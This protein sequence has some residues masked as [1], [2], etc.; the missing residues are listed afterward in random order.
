MHEGHR[1]RMLQRLKNAQDLQDHELLEI[2]L[3]NAIPRKNT[4]PTAHE[5]LSA[6]PSLSEVFRAG[7]EELLDVN[8][9]GPETAAY[10]C[11][12][13]ECGRRIR[14]QENAF[15]P[16]FN[17]GEFSGFVQKILSSLQEEVIEV[18]AIDEKE[19]IRMS[20]RFSCSLPDRVQVR[21]EEIGE[22]LARHKPAGIVIAHNHPTAPAR[23]SVEDDKFTAQM[24][25]SCSLNGVRLYDHIIV[26]TDGT[27]SYFLVGRMEEIRRNFNV[28]TIVGEKLYR[29]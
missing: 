5:L 24:Q 3:Y 21:A 15:P 11:C 7:F 1:Q 12:I 4:N 8:G 26:G 14:A 9:V 28:D 13:A 27:Y 18:F 2:L 16:I 19:R 23:P 10:L 22:F 17:P 6:F 25:L 20:R 29:V